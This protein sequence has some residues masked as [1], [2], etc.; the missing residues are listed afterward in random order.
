M[1]VN[2][3]N[4]SFPTSGVRDRMADSG[5]AF[6]DL[7]SRPRYT[8]EIPYINRAYFVNS[9]TSVPFAIPSD[10]YAEFFQDTY[11]ST[12]YYLAAAD[13][14]Q[15]R[16]LMSPPQETFS[17]AAVQLPSGPLEVMVAHATAG[18][19][20]PEC[21]ALYN[22]KPSATQVRELQQAGFRSYKSVEQVSPTRLARTEG[23][24]RAVNSV[25][26]NLSLELAQL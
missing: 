10:G 15:L 13:D 12:Y 9:R 11:T 24:S 1:V 7:N 16:Y 8:V 17:N 25:P 19:L 20:D 23:E 22:H 26:P 21:P 2:T 14:F 4:A 3:T 6:F 18:V 5:Q